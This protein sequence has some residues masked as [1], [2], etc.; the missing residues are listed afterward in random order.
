LY[1]L[2]ALVSLLARW[3]VPEKPTLPVE[4]WLEI[5]SNLTYLELQRVKRLNKNFRALVDVRGSFYSQDAP[6]NLSDLSKQQQSSLAEKLFFSPVPDQAREGTPVFLHPLLDRTRI[7]F[8][9]PTAAPFSDI[10]I[11]TATHR[12][13][14]SH[15]PLAVLRE[16]ATSPHFSSFT[17]LR[18][19]ATQF[20]LET[21]TPGTSLSVADAIEALASIRLL[22]MRR[23]ERGRMLSGS[24]DSKEESFVWELEFKQKAIPREREALK[25]NLNPFLE[26]T[27]GAPRCRLFFR[28]RVSR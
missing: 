6:A 23:Y 1:T 3:D 5:L 17:S 4:I 13:R 11:E 20:T 26:L 24:A 16:N 9:D 21:S 27:K 19:E 7:F 15:L 18:T 28:C 8:L 22:F 12:L 14:F 25:L 2:S 10:F